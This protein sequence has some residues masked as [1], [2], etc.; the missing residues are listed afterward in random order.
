MVPQQADLR[1]QGV[2]VGRDEAGVAEGAQVLRRK[3]RETGR[4]PEPPR[5]PPVTGGAERLRR[6][7]DDGELVLAGERQER[8]HVGAR[9]EQVHRHDRLRPRSHGRADGV[10]LEH[11]RDGIDV[12]EHRRGAEA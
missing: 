1:G 3:E 5:R 4:A 2:V 12:D 7:L 10:G 9:A 6:V 8:L 11:Q